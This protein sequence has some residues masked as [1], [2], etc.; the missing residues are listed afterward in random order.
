MC[1]SSGLSS[2]QAIR[3]TSWSH[4]TRPR[5]SMPFLS[6]YSLGFEEPRW[7]ALL[8]L[9]PVFWSMSFY[10]WRLAG[11]RAS[12]LALGFRSLVVTAIVLALAE[13]QIART[14]N[15]INVFYLVDRSLSV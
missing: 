15:R 5:A 1:R 14:S 12:W 7:L 9:L 11:S 2:C 6:D 10:G 3:H 4:A 8:V 13:V